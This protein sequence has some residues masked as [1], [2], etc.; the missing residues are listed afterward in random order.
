MSSFRSG[1]IIFSAYTII[2][3]LLA[4]VGWKADNPMVFFVAITG[5]LL[6]FVSSLFQFTPDNVLK[7]YKMVACVSTLMGCLFFMRLVLSHSFI[8]SGAMLFI[9]FFYAFYTTRALRTAALT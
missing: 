9:N 3:F 6:G 1:K 8:S 4:V 7:G 5:A 2:F